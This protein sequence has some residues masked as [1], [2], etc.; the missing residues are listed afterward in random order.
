MQEKLKIG[1]IAYWL[2]KYSMC[3]ETTGK[4]QAQLSMIQLSRRAFPTESPEPFFAEDT[5]LEVECEI[6]NLTLS[7]KLLLR[8]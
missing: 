7:F 8:Y 1:P 4:A 5:K 3:E 6:R 2:M